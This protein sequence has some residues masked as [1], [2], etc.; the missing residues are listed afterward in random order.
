MYDYCHYIT[1]NMSDFMH[2]IGVQYVLS[3]ALEKYIKIEKSRKK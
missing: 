1:R 3:L 2:V